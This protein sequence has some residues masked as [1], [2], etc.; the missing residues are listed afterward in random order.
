MQPS[1]HA[2][3]IDE[4]FES[5]EFPATKGNRESRINMLKSSIIHE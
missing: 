5:R 2:T 4:K 3:E 1:F